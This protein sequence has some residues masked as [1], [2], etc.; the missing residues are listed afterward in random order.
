[1]SAEEVGVFVAAL[2]TP[3]QTGDDLA[4]ELVQ[5]KKITRFQAEMIAE[6]A[7]TEHHS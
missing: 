5:A 7:W 3:P 2:K 4:N 1:M 6:G